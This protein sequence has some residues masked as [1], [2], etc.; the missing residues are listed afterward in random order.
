MRD[1]AARW[2][3]EEPASTRARNLL[4]ISHRK[5]G[6]A[7]KLD[8]D[9]DAARVE[10]A[11]AIKV[12]RAL[13]KA[14]PQDLLYQS[15]LATALDDLAGIAM[16]RRRLD[17]A[18]DLLHEAERLL[19]RRSEDDPDDVDNQVRLVLA[20]YHLGCTDR[21]AS[22]FDAARRL[23]VRALDR[24]LKLEKQRKLDGMA[25]FRDE[26][27]GLIGRAIA[28]CDGALALRPDP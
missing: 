8:H 19:L 9:L 12:G 11:A 6:D 3:E 13:L 20:H 24:L 25:T 16:A 26:W 5:L 17:E 14:E 2:V 28:D 27:T 18:R 10:Y 21:D 15:Q 4:A 1:L 22:R 23:F 7:R